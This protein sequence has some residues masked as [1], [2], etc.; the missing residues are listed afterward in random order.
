[1]AYLE[2]ENRFGPYITL[3]IRLLLFKLT[4]VY[5]VSINSG[6]ERASVQAG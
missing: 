2:N 1:V 6:A 5:T 3:A 4:A